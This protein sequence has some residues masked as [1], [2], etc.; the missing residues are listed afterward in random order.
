M[1]LFHSSGKVQVKVV[2]L[3]QKKAILMVGLRVDRSYLASW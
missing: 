1:T 3:R 2:V